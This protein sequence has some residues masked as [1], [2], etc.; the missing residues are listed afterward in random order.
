MYNINNG[1]G[2]LKILYECD[3]CGSQ[4]E[5]QEKTKECE[6][7]RTENRYQKDQM[8]R[9]RIDPNGI[10][11]NMP[12]KVGSTVFEKKT[13]KPSYEI[14]IDRATRSKL[15]IVS[16]VPGEYMSI[17]YYREVDLMPFEEA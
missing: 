6:A 7:Q 14:W 11:D 17:G 13:H 2:N 1:G 12:G 10:F 9:L 3:V 8:V 15:K 16:W 5:S 4:S